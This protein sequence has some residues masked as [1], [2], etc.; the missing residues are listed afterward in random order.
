MK[1]AVII[2]LL[3]FLIVGINAVVQVEDFD[4]HFG[5]D[6]DAEELY[7]D[8]DMDALLLELMQFEEGAE[9][10]GSSMLFKSDPGPEQ[11]VKEKF[12][13]VNSQMKANKPG[14]DAS[15]EEKLAYDAKRYSNRKSANHGLKK[16][17]SPKDYPKHKIPK[18]TDLGTGFNA[19]RA[20]IREVQRVK[21]HGVDKKEPG[22]ANKEPV[23]ANPQPGDANK[24]PVSANPKPL[25]DSAKAKEN[26][27]AA[28]SKV[29]QD[30]SAAKKKALQDVA[31]QDRPD[32]VDIYEQNAKATRFADQ[33]DKSKRELSQQH[34]AAKSTLLGMGEKPGNIPGPTTLKHDGSGY[35]TEKAKSKGKLFPVPPTDNWE[36]DEE[37]VED[38]LD[39]EED[40][41]YD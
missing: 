30:Y 23:N 15:N 38:E 26:R 22:D 20:R 21:R 28:L 41:L 18:Q 16:V 5:D 19:E 4:H 36:D 2:A 29:R 17:L 24:N 13:A 10:E 37:Y 31:S 33:M 32:G 14:P 27:A 8:L 7:E 35:R 3:F 39:Q 6:E 12:Q 40:F 1:P 34:A 11:A 9:M 25:S